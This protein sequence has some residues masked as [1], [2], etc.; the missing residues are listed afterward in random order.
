MGEQ[1]QKAAQRGGWE[2]AGSVRRFC[3]ASLLRT[4]PCSTTPRPTHSLDA[5]TMTNFLPLCCARGCPHSSGSVEPCGGRWFVCLL[6]ARWRVLW[7]LDTH[8]VD[9]W[10]AKNKRRRPLELLCNRFAGAGF[11]GSCLCTCRAVPARP[12]P[13][14]I[15]DLHSDRSA[16]YAKTKAVT[17]TLDPLTAAMH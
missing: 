1:Q 14:T 8:L 11:W 12:L 16:F 4:Q 6:A 3:A 7:L 2:R 5:V 9:D 10:K 13:Q 15:Q 17:C